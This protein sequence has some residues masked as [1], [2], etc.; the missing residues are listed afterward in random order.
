MGET[1]QADYNSCLEYCKGDTECN[2]ITFFADSDA[3]VAFDDCSSIEDLCSSCFTGESDC[4]LYQPIC[5]TP[6]Q[7][8]GGAFLAESQQVSYNDC[9]DFCDATPGCNWITHIA[10]Q[11]VCLAFGS[12]PSITEDCEGCFSGE[13]TCPDSEPIC[14]VQGQCNGPFIAFLETESSDACLQG[15]KDADG[16]EW[17]NFDMATGFCILTG[18]CSEIDETCGSCLTGQVSCD[19]NSVPGECLNDK[20]IYSVLIQ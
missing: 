5:Y 2:W 14:N 9:L 10:G 8:T 18:P 7:C 13:S 17:Y 19:V 6:G 12:C 16:C 1:S 4:P 20:C 3:C 11:Q 15:C